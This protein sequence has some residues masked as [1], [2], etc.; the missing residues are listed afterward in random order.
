MK[1][2]EGEF[3]VVGEKNHEVV[4]GGVGELGPLG[5]GL[6]RVAGWGG[7]LECGGEVSG[8]GLGGAGG[9]GGGWEGGGLH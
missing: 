3:V 7:G 4:V 9:G 1:D 2:S 6:G 5:R 8:L